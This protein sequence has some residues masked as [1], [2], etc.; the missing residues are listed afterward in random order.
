ME[1]RPM[2]YVPEIIP[3]DERA[4]YARGTMGKRVGFGARPAVLVVDMTRAFTEDRFPLGCSVAGAPCAAA[5]RTL[6]DA[7][8]LQGVP[9]LYTRYDAFAADAEWGAGSTRARAPSPTPACGD[10]R[11]TR[12][13]TRSS[14]GR[15]ISW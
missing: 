12:S 5:I 8:R 2:A 3:P 9:V 4:R 1:A 15:G 10:P 6:L 14:P 11:R 7:V 13:P